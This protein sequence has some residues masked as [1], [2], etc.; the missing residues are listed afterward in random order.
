MW[1]MSRVV[2]VLPFVPVTATIGIVE[3]TP[4]G[5]SMSM[6]GSATFRASPEV[7]CRCIRKPG[8][9]LI[10]TMPPPFSFSGVVRSGAIISTPP[11]SSPISRIARSAMWTFAGWTSSVMSIAVPPVERF[12]VVFSV[13]ISPFGSTDFRV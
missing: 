8:A 4:G 7:G 13:S 9:A 5:K 11:M 6:T 10:S 12:A 3:R 1:L 2:V